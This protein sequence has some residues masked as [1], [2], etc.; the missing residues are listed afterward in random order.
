VEI[1]EGLWDLVSRGLVA[2]DGFH[3][4][5]SLLGARERW[6]K[7]RER[8]DSRRRLRRGAR[9]HA[10]ADGRWALLP[11][12]DD[13]ADRDELAEAVCEQLLAR[14][15]VVFYDLLAR[16]SLALPW[17]DLVWAMRRME[18]RGSIRGGRFVTGFSG[19]QF[20]LPGAVDA[21]RRTRKLERT[22]EEVLLSAADPLNLAGILTPGPRIPS[23]RAK[24]VLFR[25]GVPVPF[26]ETS[27]SPSAPRHWRR[28]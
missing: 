4:L 12:A 18:A 2:A 22:G 11:R 20:A 24:S 3:A 21:L 26:E 13:T 7:R 6:T 23:V 8:K 10:G 9:G 19:E 28:A 14:Y 25:D 15:G 17:R 5:R 16:E 27:A 1:E